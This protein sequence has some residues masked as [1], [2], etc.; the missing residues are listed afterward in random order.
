[1]ECQNRSETGCEIGVWHWNGNDLVSEEDGVKEAWT[2][3][4]P[5]S[6]TFYM[7]NATDSGQMKR[8]MT[9]EYTRVGGS[10]TAEN[11]KP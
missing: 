11:K 10:N 3:I 6:R 7:E 4:T 9:I 2:K 1:M 8:L 5:T